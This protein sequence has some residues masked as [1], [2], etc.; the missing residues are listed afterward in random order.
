MAAIEALLEHL[1][2]VLR[3]G[4]LLDLVDLHHAPAGRHGVFDGTD[5]S[6]GLERLLHNPH[7]LAAVHG[8]HDHGQ[9]EGAGDEDSKAA[10][11]DLAEPLEDLQPVDEGQMVVD[12]GDVKGTV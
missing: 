2:L 3:R 12:Q 7:D 1:A 11:L 8:L 10:R 5:Q 4:L 6:G 9:V